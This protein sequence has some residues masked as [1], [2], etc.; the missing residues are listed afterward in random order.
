MHARPTSPSASERVY[1]RLKHDILDG[2]LPGGEFF[3]E[4]SVADEVGV[5]RTPVREALLRLEVEG[6]VR[7]YPKKG[8]LVVPVTQDEARQVLEAREVVEVW[9]AGAMWPRR[10]EVLPQLRELLDD[11][12]SAR[13]AGD[14]T[15]FVGHDRRFHEVLVEAAGNDI[16]SRA[17]EGLRDRQLRIIASQMLMSRS[18]M[19]TAMRGH[20]E[21]VELLQSGRKAELVAAT[22]AHVRGAVA[23]IRGA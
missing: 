14:V 9:A 4:G 3:T 13:A 2:S 23:A 19:D 17:Y 12:R 10:V 6:L 1:D 5:S 15:Q 22:R 16:L 21:I 7:L 8:A 11:M 18:R 20:A